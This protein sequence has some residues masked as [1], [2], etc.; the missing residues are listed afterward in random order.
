MR[1]ISPGVLEVGYLAAQ[2]A[3]N[4]T[5]STL[6][7][8]TRPAVN[9]ALRKFWELCRDTVHEDYA[10]LMTEL[11]VEHLDDLPPGLRR[12]A[13]RHIGQ[14]FAAAAK[15]LGLVDEAHGF[16]LTAEFPTGLRVSKLFSGPQSSPLVAA[17]LLE[18]LASTNADTAFKAMWVPRSKKVTIDL[19]DLLERQIQTSPD[20]S[21][22]IATNYA[23]AAD[24]LKNGKDEILGLVA[25]Q[26]A[27]ELGFLGEYAEDYVLER[28]ARTHPSILSRT[29]A[30]IALAKRGRD[31]FHEEAVSRRRY[32]TEQN[33]RDDEERLAYY[34]A[35]SGDRSLDLSIVRGDVPATPINMIEHMR[36]TIIGEPNFLPY[37][38]I[39]HLYELSRLLGQRPAIL[40]QN[41]ELST[42]LED[43]LIT[44]D[45]P[46]NQDFLILADT[47]KAARA[48]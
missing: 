13:R 27:Y 12:E 31:E 37:N 32:A 25:C 21:A 10:A 47:L 14:L 16:R 3:S 24:R 20:L 45:V 41:P 17:F 9:A 44:P 28:Q 38:R 35:W 23:E 36:N 11:Q 6:T 5:I 29:S 39:L 48:A 26:V 34:A 30:A 15:E 43:I 18:G 42:S 2:G 8:K 1:A 33:Q 4:A 7:G 19:V 40:T 22:R 46:E